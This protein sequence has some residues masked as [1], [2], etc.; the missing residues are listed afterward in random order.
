LL[1]NNLISPQHQEWTFIFTGSLF[2]LITELLKPE[3]YKSDPVGMSETRVRASTL[4]SKVYLHHLTMLAEDT[5]HL[6]ELW[7]EVITF[8]DRLMNSG[9][10]DNLVGSLP[11]RLAR[12]TMFANRL[13]HRRKPCQKT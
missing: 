11:R 12:N 3:V 7:V 2:P 1:S 5:E 4:L 10:G 9:Q 13:P 6:L 8:M